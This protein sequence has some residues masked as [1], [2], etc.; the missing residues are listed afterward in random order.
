MLTD[1]E[2]RRRLEP[3]ATL[4]PSEDDL[5]A[6]R[7]A[8]LAHIRTKPRRRRPRA[9][10]VLT[11]AAAAGAFAI[12]ILPAARDA[13]RTPQPTPPLVAA[14]AVAAQRTVP[15]ADT[16]PYRYTRTRRTF[17][18]EV[19]RDGRV[20]GERFELAVERWVG[21]RWRG[22]EIGS[23]SHRALTGDLALAREQFG[24]RS[25]PFEAYDRPYA[26]GDGP[27]A[28][29]DPRTLPEDRKT[30]VRVLTTG[31]R[32][33]RWGPYA[34]SRGRPLDMPEDLLRS[35]TAHHTIL[36]LVHARLTPVQRAALLDMLAAEAPAR[37][38]GTV[39]D[40][41]GRRG[42]GVELSYPIGGGRGVDPDY[43]RY[44]IVFDP[45]TAEV[46][47]W[48]LEPRGGVNPGSP[49]SVETVIEAGW[50]QRAGERP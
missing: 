38:L 37:D 40:A 35:V 44:R 22:R 4:E 31:I 8:E 34:S 29:L 3:V 13:Q 26:Y 33:D 12:A 24:K 30:L 5:A 2:I 23:A 19:R 15:A 39:T 9:A 25:R 21:P 50:A 36:L 10:I 27:L 45:T 14:A 42:R 16:A 18:Y 6:L 49:Y 7:A 43:E 32:T 28:R 47:E 11:L 1:E 48:S 41:I 20:G 46:L 17:T